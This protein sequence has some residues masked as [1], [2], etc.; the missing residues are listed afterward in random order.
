MEELKLLT[1]ILKDVPNSI[2]W[3]I[4]FY[5]MLKLVYVGSLYGVLKLFINKC[6]EW[7]MA[8]KGEGK[9]IIVEKSEIER[10]SITHDGTYDKILGQLKRIRSSNYIHQRGADTLRQALDEYEEKYGELT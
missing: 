2:I 4:G 9:K 3:I 10:I 7:A 5:F 6:H 8:K 1:D